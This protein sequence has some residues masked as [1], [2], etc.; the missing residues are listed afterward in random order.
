VSYDHYDFLRTIEEIFGVS[1]M[2]PGGDGAA[3][4]IGGIW[5]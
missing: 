2:V 5:K 4:P 3:H 1:P